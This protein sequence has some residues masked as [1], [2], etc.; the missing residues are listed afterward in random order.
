MN[1][2]RGVTQP[3]LQAGHDKSFDQGTLVV[4]LGIELTSLL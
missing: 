1:R 2:A 3:P 4:S